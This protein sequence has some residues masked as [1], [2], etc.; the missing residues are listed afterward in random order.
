MGAQVIKS[1][2]EWERI[3]AEAMTGYK[4]IN[5]IAKAH[6]VPESTVRLRL[7]KASGAD[8]SAEIKRRRVRNAATLGVD[9]TH[10]S[11]ARANQIIAE[12]VT[13][14]VADMAKGVEASRQILE[15]TM[16]MISGL[17]DVRELK[18]AADTVKTTIETIRKIRGLDDENDAPGSGYERLSDAELIDELE[19][20]QQGSAL[21]ADSY[22]QGTA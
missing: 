6:G 1:D 3:L 13:Q 10:E 9:T 7:K 22:T 16:S 20:L 18:T 5:S 14:D 15:R 21:T 2:E 19:R 17:S 4:S 11:M 12:A 8:V